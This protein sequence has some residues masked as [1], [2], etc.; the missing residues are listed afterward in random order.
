VCGVGRTK[1]D[2]ALAVVGEG[3]AIAER[4]LPEKNECLAGLWRL[5]NRAWQK[6]AR[7]NASEW[8]VALDW[9]PMMGQDRVRW[10]LRGMS[11]QR[12]DWVMSGSTTPLALGV[13]SA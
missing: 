10:P 8:P 6:P 5:E 13:L 2:L 9:P 3:P 4:I 12:Q 11:R 7:A 1:D